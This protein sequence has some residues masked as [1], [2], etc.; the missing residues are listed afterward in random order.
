VCFWKLETKGSEIMSHKRRVK[1][2]VRGVK[3]I[4]QDRE[5]QQIFF[6]A[7]SEPLTEELIQE[8][9]AKGWPEED[10]RVLAG[11]GQTYCRPRNSLMGPSYYTDSRGTFKI[12]PERR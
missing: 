6:G 3:N 1:V 2:K 12:S 4:S 11:E 5:I 8:L 10:L 7:D 9:I